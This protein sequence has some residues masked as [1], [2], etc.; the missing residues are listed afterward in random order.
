MR[1]RIGVPIQRINL[2]VNRKRGVTPD[3]ALRLGRFLGTTA[4]FWLAGQLAWDL[5]QEMNSKG[6]RDINRIRPLAKAR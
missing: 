2:L 4:Q 3:T 5:Y 6:V 1:P